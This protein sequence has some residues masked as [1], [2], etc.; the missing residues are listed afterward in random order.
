MPNGSTSDIGWFSGGVIPGTVGTA[1][2]DAH[3]FAGFS[4]LRVLK[5]GDDIYVTDANGQ[6]VHFVVMATKT[7]ALSELTP[8]MLFEETTG[9]HLNLITCAGSLT[10]DH[11]TYD[12]RLIVYAELAGS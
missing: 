5:V 12:H 3:V 4:M 11:T 10:P 8:D 2:M 9:R 7:Y 1:V 6:Q